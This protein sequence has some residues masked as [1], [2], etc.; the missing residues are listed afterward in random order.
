MLRGN[1]IINGGVFMN[2]KI[3]TL[4]IIIVIGITLLFCVF[5]PSQKSVSLKND[6][7]NFLSSISWNDKKTLLSLGFIEYSLNEFTLDYGTDCVMRVTLVDGKNDDHFNF[8][9]YETSNKTIVQRNGHG[10]YKN[11]NIYVNEVDEVSKNSYPLFV[12]Y[13][14]IRNNQIS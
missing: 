12:S 2:K 3:I 5:L 7:L 1:T 6:D 11:A 14:K 4:I 8:D 9:L 10:V 13:L